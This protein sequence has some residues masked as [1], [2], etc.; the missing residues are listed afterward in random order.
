MSTQFTLDATTRTDLG[1]G[2]SRRL[3]RIDGLVPAVIY[4]A[5]K[6]PQSIQLEHRFV[7][8]ALEN[9]AFYTQIIDLKIN[10]QAEQVILKDLQ[11]HPYKPLILHMD[12]LRIKAGEKIAVNI[13]FHF[14][15]E[16]VA[17]GVKLEG[18]MASHLAN[19]AEITCLPKDLPEF[20]DVD[21]S[22]M[23]LDDVLHLSDIKLAKGLSFTA[24]QHDNDIAIA[25]IHKAKVAKEGATEETSEDAADGAGGQDNA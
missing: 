1:K 22:N 3:R 8:K 9:E 18:G 7:I 24:L 2:A 5:G 4:G 10:N 25:S 6:D 12:F 19:E 15:G 21:L 23:H 14:T 11:R 16:D 20:I 17:P 13:P